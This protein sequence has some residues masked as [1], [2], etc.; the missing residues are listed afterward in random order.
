MQI[1][2]MMLGLRHTIMFQKKSE[3][4]IIDIGANIGSF[5][6]KLAKKCFDSKKQFLIYSF[7][8]NKIIF[9]LLKNNLSLNKDISKN[10]YP[11]QIPLGD[12]NT[13]V[14]FI[15]KE[16]NSG[17]SKVLKSNKDLESKLQTVKLKQI[18]LDYFVENNEIDHIDIIKIDV[19]GY[20]P[21]VLDGCINTIK[22]Y[23]P[24]LYIEITPMWFKDIGR[25]SNE[26]LNFLKSI[27]YK[28]YLDNQDFLKPI[29]NF[30]LLSNIE[31][32]NILAKYDA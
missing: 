19:E 25:S 26:I 14:D 24:I 32:Y 11:F 10:I 28:I 8:P 13:E 5:S 3:L 15:N 20:E 4:I 9:N 12:K 30:K 23:K 1:L 31:Q 2:R 27:G 7:E 18:S 6:L 21:I 17:G 29:E 16:Q 22:K